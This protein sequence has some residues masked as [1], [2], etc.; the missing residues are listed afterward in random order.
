MCLHSEQN[1][2]NGGHGVT[3]KTIDIEEKMKRIGNSLSEKIIIEVMTVPVDTQKIVLET[4]HD[5][6]QGTRVK[7]IPN[8]DLGTVHMSE[9]TGV[10]EM[11]EA[12]EIA[13][14]TK[15][16]EKKTDM[17]ITSTEMVAGSEVKE[18]PTTAKS[19]AGEDRMIRIE[20]KGR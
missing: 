5:Q 9:V 7:G 19:Q 12:P 10:L 3:L 14:I 8:Q 16:P 20:C 17:Q 2:V 6:G 15:T 1:A 18:V 11:K 4:G 13:K